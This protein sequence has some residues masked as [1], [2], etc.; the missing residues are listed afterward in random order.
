MSRN[1]GKI[2]V[3]TGGTT[4]IGLATAQR[5]VAEGRLRLHHRTPPGRAGR[6][7]EAHRE[8]V[9]G[10]QGDVSKLADLDRLFE[11]VKRE[12][13]QLDILFVNAG[14]AKKTT[15]GNVSEEQFDR[16]FDINV[17]GAFFTVQKALPSCATGPR[18]S[19]TRR[20]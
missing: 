16:E 10:V 11:I 13:G 7:R 12:K 3:V 5:L 1:Q 15:F 4:G 8:N 9:T 18:S 2:A 17:K 19:S 14:V 20:S 6:G